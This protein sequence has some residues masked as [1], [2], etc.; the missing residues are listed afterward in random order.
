MLGCTDIQ[1]CWWVLNPTK[2]E[3]SYNDRRFWISY[4]LFI[5]IIG[6]ILIL[7]LYIT[8]LASI[9]IFSSSNKIHREVGRAK[10]LSAPLY[11][12]NV[13]FMTS[14]IESHKYTTHI[15]V[16]NF[17]LPEAINNAFTWKNIIQ[18]SGADQELR[19]L[20]LIQFLEPSLRKR[21]QNY[22]YNVRYNVNIYL[23]PH[24]APWKGPVQVRGPETWA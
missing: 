1:G 17:S 3:K 2:K 19:G 12:V 20:K 9:E 18:Q 23:G 4:I 10:D 15:A 13:C 16:F 8:R 7:F 22:E 6:G 21:I 14:R 5:I 24:P 11:V